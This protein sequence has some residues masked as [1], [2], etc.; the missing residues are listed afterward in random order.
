[1]KIL[2]L[3]FFEDWQ[4]KA[5]FN[6]NKYEIFCTLVRKRKNIFFC[7]YANILQ[8]GENSKKWQICFLYVMHV[9]RQIELSQSSFDAIF[10]YHIARTNIMSMRKITENDS[11][12]KKINLLLL[13]RK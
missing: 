3:L 4:N 7:C 6:R 10:I 12:C 13:K 2:L 8:L 5:S 1:V 11:I 9:S